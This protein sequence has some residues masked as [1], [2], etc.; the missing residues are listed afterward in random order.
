MNKWLE[1]LRGLNPQEVG[2]WPLPFKLGG[3]G[4]AVNASAVRRVLV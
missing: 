1:Q 2:S 4:V 3:P